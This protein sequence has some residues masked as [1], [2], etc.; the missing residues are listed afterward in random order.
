MKIGIITKH[1]IQNYGSFAQAY[2]LQRTLEELGH[3][4][5]I[6]D[7]KY[8]NVAHP[9]YLTLKARLLKVANTMLKNLLGLKGWRLNARYRECFGTYY[10]LSRPYP[11]ADALLSDPPQYDAY[12]SG[13]D[14]IWRPELTNGDPMFFLAFAPPGAKRVALAS[15]FGCV[16]I[17]DAL[18]T[19]YATRLN[20][21]DSLAVREAS[22][23]RLVKEL[24]G[25]TATQ[26]I[27]PSMLLTGDEWR[28]VA[29]PSTIRGRYVV[30][31]G[32]KEKAA[33]NRL[34][35]RYAAAHGCRVVRIVGNFFD[36]F[37]RGETYVI[38]A[39]PRE[40]MG[41]VAGAEMAFI[42]G[43]FHG[44]VFATLFNVPFVT[45]LTGNAD[46]DSRQLDLVRLLG[47]DRCA[48][49]TQEVDMVD[50]TEVRAALDFVRI[51]RRVG[52]MRAAAVRFMREALVELE[53]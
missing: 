5:E 19:A 10:H 26:M 16:A 9:A 41:L 8:P 3:Q 53:R 44:T 37:R 27:D 32:S 21:Y 11:T 15:S 4:V 30:C 18:R 50:F 23:V 35:H 34:A 6:I 51:N 52:E 22:G 2:A 13:S 46:Q 12:V 43:S 14:Q 38:D 40:W 7:Y 31:Y 48:V 45:V 42:G 17:P 36:W 25:R 49:E 47:V 20:A 29:R 1:A 24:T 28:A 39:G 33:V